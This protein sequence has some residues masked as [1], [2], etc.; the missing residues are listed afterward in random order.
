M[1]SRALQSIRRAGEEQEQQ[2]SSEFLIYGTRSS[3][4]KS[5]AYLFLPDGEAKVQEPAGSCAC[6]PTAA[7]PAAAQ[8]SPPPQPYAPKDPPVV[9]V[10]EGPLFSEVAS[11]YQHVQIVV[12]LY[13]VPGETCVAVLGQSLARGA[14][15]LTACPQ[16][17]RACPWR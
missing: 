10:T 8:H 5:G 11:Y 1:L 17:W 13:N 14:Q 16:G 9:R 6:G 7:L 4:D 3:K 12:R 15:P 2:V